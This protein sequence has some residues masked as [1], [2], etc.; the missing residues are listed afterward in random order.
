MFDEDRVMREYNKFL[1]RQN[2]IAQ[3]TAAAE[4]RP[5]EKPPKCSDERFAAMINYVR[6]NGPPI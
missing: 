6:K 3:A 4:G 1:V 5:H 2:Q